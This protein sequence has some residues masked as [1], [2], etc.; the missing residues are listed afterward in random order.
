MVIKDKYYSSRFSS[1]PV[2]DTRV[3]KDFSSWNL[4]LE[5]DQI[6]N[7]SCDF[8]PS[9]VSM[10]KIEIFV[11]VNK[12]DLNKINPNPLLGPGRRRREIL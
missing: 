8:D 7:L 4:N 5:E 10:S 11:D 2:S 12:Q 9:S 6:T 1:K 3:D